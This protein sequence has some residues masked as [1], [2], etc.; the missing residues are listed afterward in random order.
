VLYATEGTQ[1]RNQYGDDPKGN[2]NEI[3]EIGQ[4]QF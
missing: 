2:Y 3:N 4:K 1:G